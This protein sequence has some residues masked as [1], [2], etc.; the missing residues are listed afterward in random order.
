MAGLTWRYISSVN[1]DSSSSNPL[2][3]GAFNPPD[4][5]IGSQS[6]FDL[7]LQWAINKNF[8]VRGGINNLFDKDPP[9]VT[10]TIAGPSVNGNGNTFPGVYDYLGRNIFLGITAKF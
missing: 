10:Q 4:L 1:V 7:A 5:E 2:L 9:V 3:T 6:Y 8:S